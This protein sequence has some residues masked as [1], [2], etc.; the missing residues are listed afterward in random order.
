MDELRTEG[1]GGRR[2]SRVARAARRAARLDQSQFVARPLENVLGTL[3]LLTEEQVED[4]HEA[5]LGLL[6]EIGIEF[7]GAKR[8]G[9][10][11]GGR[12]HRRRRDRPRAD[13]ARG[14]RGRGHRRSAGV[15]RHPARPDPADPDRREE[16]RVRARRR[17]ADRAGPRARPPP[18]QPRRLHH[19]AEART[20]LRRD[21]LRRQ[22]AD[23]AGRAAAHH[24]PPR[25]VPRQR[26]VHGSRLP[27]PCDRTRP[28]HRRDRDHGHLAWADARAGRRRPLRLHDHLRQLPAPLRRGDVGR[29]DRDGRARAAL[30]RSRRSR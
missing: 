30:C 28:G 18:G 5:S 8:P 21:P 16:R 10:V 9:H 14:R 27:L 2:R 22:P 3:R 24:P 19:A 15:H 29:P 11:S 12:C 7:M 25:H 17:P 23:T 4:V 20:E 13:P 6:E 1:A 26:H